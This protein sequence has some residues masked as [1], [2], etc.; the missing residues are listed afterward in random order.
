MLSAKVPRRQPVVLLEGAIEAEQITESVRDGA[1]RPNFFSNR[2]N[3]WVSHGKVGRL[4][5]VAGVHRQ[6]LPPISI[7]QTLMVG[8][9][10]D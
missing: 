10:N 8:D 4:H 6:N 1:Q 5:S 2:P 9:G 3:D 7:K